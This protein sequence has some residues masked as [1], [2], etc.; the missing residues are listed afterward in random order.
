MSDSAYGH[1]DISCMTY[2][3][4]V[5]ILLACVFVCVTI[6]RA[7]RWG[8]ILV[9]NY[10]YWALLTPSQDPLSGTCLVQASDLHMGP[11]VG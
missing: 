1:E 7:L 9:G 8:V 11:H 4:H 3:I 10:H 2:D 6:A 5:D